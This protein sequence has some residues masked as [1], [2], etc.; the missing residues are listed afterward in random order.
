MNY[1]LISEYTESILSAEDNFNELAN[2]R[3]V[4][5]SYGRPVMSS[6]NF[7]VVYKMRDI[8]TDKLYAVKCFTREQTGREDAYRE[9]SDY[10]QNVYCNFIVKVKYYSDELFVDTNQSDTSEFPVLVMDWIDGIGL[11][12]YISQ[13]ADNN[14]KLELLSANFIAMIGELLPNHFAH[15]DLKPDNIIIDKDGNI[16][17]ID[18]DGM[19]VPSMEGQ[20]SPELGTPQFQ[21]SN[22]KPEDFNEYI[23]DYGALYLA[24]LLRLIAISDKT[25]DNVV[26]VNNH[27][28][29]SIV[30]EYIDDVIISKLLSAF[31]LVCNRGFVE[32]EVLSVCLYNEN[33]YNREKEL[34]YVSRARK[35]DTTAM[36]LLGDTYSRGSF[37]PTNSSKAIDW[38]YLAKAMGN[39]NASCGI[40]RHFYHFEN[41]FYGLS[42][43][44]NL[45][46]KNLLRVQNDFSL[47]REG[48]EYM[49]KDHEHAI[50]F[51][52]KAAELKFAPAIYWLSSFPSESENKIKLIEEAANMDYTRAL[53][54]LGECHRKGEHGCSNDQKIALSYYRRAAEAGDDESQYII[55]LAYFNGWGDY[56]RNITSAIV[57]LKMASEQGHKE[58][59]CELAKIYL[60][61]KQVKQD[62]SYSLKLLNRLVDCVRPHNEALYIL[63]ICSLYGIG[64]NVDFRKAI[65]YFTKAIHSG[66]VGNSPAEIMLDYILRQYGMTDETYV[67][68]SEI[69]DIGITNT[70]KYSEDNKRFL[71]YWGSY[72]EEYIIKDGTEVLCDNSFN[73]LY[74]ECDGYYL[75]RLIIP[76][77][78]KHIGNN[79]FC[80]SIKH[81]ECKSSRFIVEND[82]LLSRDKC[83]LYRYFGD[84]TRVN[85]PYG[86]KYIKGG[87]FTELNITKI[88]IPESVIYIG[89]NPFAGTGYYDYDS[90]DFKHA[91]IIS[92]S[93][94]IIVDGCCIY[95]KKDHSLVACWN[96]SSPVIIKPWCKVIGE[97]A[98][99]D[100]ELESIYLPSSIA[101]IR[102]TALWGHEM[103]LNN[104]SVDY[105]E[106]RR[107]KSL[108][109][110]YL[111]KYITELPNPIDDLPF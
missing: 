9:I 58:A 5:D 38:Y 79:V 109:P 110:S 106:K 7:A 88:I 25:F 52:R 40:C 11:E 84:E 105:G 23:D 67:N 4:L 42:I 32:R 83:I 97:N 35:G 15:G 70:G 73:D 36:I 98:F 102:K 89:A 77:S 101:T 46:H 59:A 107:F 6:G 72:G 65:T 87:A 56:D 57:W 43:A 19:F 51:F 13:N 85:I 108:I 29:I 47:C 91:E 27:E 37:T 62:I 21:Y 50:K 66:L 30:G 22:R 49:F 2:L 80:A 44:D 34:S 99:W 17:L 81:I 100:A 92:N 48:E 33:K 10:L 94:H 75:K 45:I 69:I 86:V 82:M 63:G 55:G 24:L 103:R 60:R 8:V 18:Y 1:P 53:K 28:F 16:K 71:C 111:S 104:I 90:H 20:V 76:E 61:G 68:E 12:E 14:D 74:S 93:P 26:S 3:P 96:R 31:L 39:I 64:V 54:H 78:V 41:D 95:S